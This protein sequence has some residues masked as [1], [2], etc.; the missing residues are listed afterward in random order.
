MPWINK[1]FIYF[2]SIFSAFCF[3]HYKGWTDLNYT[4]LSQQMIYDDVVS[5]I[6]CQFTY[7]EVCEPVCPSEARIGSSWHSWP[8]SR[9][10]AERSL[11]SQ[12]AGV[13]NSPDLDRKTVLK[14]AAWLSTFFTVLGKCKGQQNFSLLKQLELFKRFVP[15]DLKMFYLY[16][17]GT[18]YYRRWKASIYFSPRTKMFSTWAKMEKCNWVKGKDTFK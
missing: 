5:S 16:A 6:Y 1:P 7:K 8:Q 14:L 3:G 4:L 12:T 2:V 15:Y 9:D 17:P 10:R 13:I 18:R 11:V